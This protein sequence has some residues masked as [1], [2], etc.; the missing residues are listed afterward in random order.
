MEALIQAFLWLKHRVMGVTDCKPRAAQRLIERGMP[1]LD[2]REAVELEWARLS[3]SLHIPLPDLEARQAEL[4]HLRDVEFLVIC[5]GGLRSG[6]ACRKLR[7]RGFQGPVNMA[8]GILAWRAAGLPTDGHGEFDSSILDV[9]R[10]RLR[11]KPAPRDGA[12]S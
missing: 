11:D 5:H 9:A 6:D 4:D 1:V 8:G 12:P 2:V 3:G 7:Q 10:R